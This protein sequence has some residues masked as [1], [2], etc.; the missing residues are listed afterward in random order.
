MIDDK[1]IKENLFRANGHLKFNYKKLIETYN[2]TDYLMSR[3]S[4]S[5]S[6]EESLNRIYHNIEIRPVCALCGNQVKYYKQNKFSEFC[7]V[8]CAMNSNKVKEKYKNSIREKYGVDNVWQHP[9]IKKKIKETNIKKY[10]VDSYLKSEEGKRRTKETCIEKYGVDCTGKIPGRLE[11]V[12]DSNRKNLGVDWPMQSQDVRNKGKETCLEKYGSEY[13][14]QS[15]EFKMHFDDKEWVKN[16]KLK[17]FKS[18]KEKG[19]FNSSKEEK[20]ILEILKQ[21]FDDVNY[22]YYDERYGYVC[23]YYIKKYDLFIEYNGHW[24]HGEHTFNRNDKHDNELLEQWKI[25]AET[26]KFYKNAV[27][28]WSVRDI[29]KINNAKQ[30]DLRLAILWTEDFLNNKIIEKIKQYIENEIS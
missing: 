11:K 12:K 20:D 9:D 6:V 25:K 3:F 13:Y 22:Q 21:E 16:A 26:S 18:K 10:G 7:S 5:S 4:D 28:T 30:K 27:E 1:F 8:K 17:E 19:N 24:T 23:D 29:K 2:L 15:D 14:V